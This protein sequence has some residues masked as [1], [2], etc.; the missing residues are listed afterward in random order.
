MDYTKLSYYLSSVIGLRIYAKHMLYINTT[1]V[2]D[3]YYSNMYW[4]LARYIYLKYLVN[5]KN[6]C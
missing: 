5:E 2:K 1:H 3:N 6:R 4:Y